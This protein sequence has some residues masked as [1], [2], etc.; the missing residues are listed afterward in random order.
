M[1]TVIISYTAS[2][3]LYFTFTLYCHCKN[4]CDLHWGGDALPAAEDLVQ[5]L[6]AQDVPQRGL[7]Q[8]PAGM[9]HTVSSTLWLVLQGVPYYW[10]HFVNDPI[11]IVLNKF[12]KNEHWLYVVKLTLRSLVPTLILHY[13]AKITRNSLNL[14]WRYRTK[15]WYVPIDVDPGIA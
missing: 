6:R 11:A 4:K 10:T 15:C 5:V 7:G 8:Q 12:P 3:R 2:T 1:F 9:T 13:S 14:I